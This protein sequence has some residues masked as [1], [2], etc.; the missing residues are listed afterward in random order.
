[1][2]EIPVS[3]S[4]FCDLHIHTVCSDGTETSVDIVN[5]AKELNLQAIAI[6][7]HDTM[8]G[9][10]DALAEGRSI[11]VVVIPGIEF[12]VMSPSGPIHLLAYGISENDTAVRVLLQQIVKG[13]NERNVRILEKLRECGFPIS[14]EELI[15]EAGNE[16]IV[17][18]PHIANL[19]LK[20]N[21]CS[22]FE[23]IY[24]KYLG[25]KGKAY[26][27]RFRPLF[28][29][30]LKIIHEAGGL[31]VLAHPGFYRDLISPLCNW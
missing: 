25:N 21:Y 18:R 8:G 22:S 3:S 4:Q 23:E 24:S 5:H 1:M 10:K 2:T 11:G 27:E 17:G 30:T 13:R 26:V 14:Y 7:D 19:M 16:N 9:V 29:D 6:T 28:K 20:K 15:V 12:S 31:A